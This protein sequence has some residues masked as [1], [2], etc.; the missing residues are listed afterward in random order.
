MATE[1]RV[2]AASEV[3]EGAVKGVSLGDTDILLANVGGTVYAL[4]DI[5][6]HAECSI[7]EGGILEGTEVECPCHGSRF[8]VTTGEVTR[9]P[10]VEAL[11]VYRVSVKNGDILV[12]LE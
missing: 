6:T 11:Q 1:E 9:P 8:D 4:S 2:A 5:C 10:A 3:P 7:S 12:T